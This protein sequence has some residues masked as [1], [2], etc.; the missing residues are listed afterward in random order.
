MR[1]GEIIRRGRAQVLSNRPAFHVLTN[2]DPATGRG[3]QLHD[4][5]NEERGDEK[6]ETEVKRETGA[7][8]IPTPFLCFPSPRSTFPHG[9]S[10]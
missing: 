10:N 3:G 1:A 6:Q 7:R 8:S 9:F 5:G 2:F 4:A